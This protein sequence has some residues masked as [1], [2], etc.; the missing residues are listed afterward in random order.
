[1][2]IIYT[3]YAFIIK[4][5][6]NVYYD[7]NYVLAIFLILFIFVFMHED[8]MLVRNKYEDGLLR[9]IALYINPIRH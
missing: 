6:I 1:M 8:D 4:S 5:S 2:C 3:Y 7:E 9:K